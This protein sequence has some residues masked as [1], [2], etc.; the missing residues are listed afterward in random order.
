MPTNQP[1]RTQDRTRPPQTEDLQR[2]PRWARVAY[3]VRCAR[4]VQPL[5][6]TLWPTAPEK[7]VVAIERALYTAASSSSSGRLLEDAAIVLRAAAATRAAPHTC[8]ADAARAAAFAADA[9]RT[10][11]FGS[12]YAAAAADAAAEASRQSQKRMIAAAWHDNDALLSMSRGEAW[13]NHKDMRSHG[14]SWTDHTPVNPDSLG[15]LWPPDIDEREGWP[16]DTIVPSD[17][18]KLEL[19]ILVPEGASDDEVADI[20]KQHVLAASRTH[21]SH[22]GSGLKIDAIEVH[23]E[24]LLP[25]GVLR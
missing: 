24:A 4:R 22:R 8:A 9:A 7:H 23:Q 3:A 16:T 17:A 15:P 11:L 13:G 5:F 1:D 12:A 19:Q 14:Q 21:Q 25:V 18:H 20:V 10:V 2:L 6:T